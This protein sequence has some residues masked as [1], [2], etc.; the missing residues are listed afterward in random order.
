MQTIVKM[1]RAQQTTIFFPLRFFSCFFLFLRA[2]PAFSTVIKVGH[3]QPVGL[4]QTNVQLTDFCVFFFF[5]SP[6]HGIAFLTN[7]PKLARNYLHTF[8]GPFFFF[9]PALKSSHL[10]DSFLYV[11]GASL[12]GLKQENYPGTRRHVSKN[13]W[14]GIE[15]TRR[16]R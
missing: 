9:Y 12:C 16:K 13:R 14:D 8:H 7:R 10:V 3:L 15:I 4:N 2:A 5:H 11:N 1:S 6:V